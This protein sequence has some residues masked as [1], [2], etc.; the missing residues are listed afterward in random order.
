MRCFSW[1]V[2][3]IRSVARKQLL[4][5]EV[6]V[7]ADLI[8][9]QETKAQEH[10]LE[11]ELASPAGWHASWHSAEKAGY[12][13]V[14]I[15]SRDKPDEVVAGLGDPQFDVEGRV[16]SARFGSLWV[17]SAYFPNSQE[18]GRRLPYKLAFCAA[19]EAFTGRLRAGGREVLLMGDYNIAH[20]PIDL[21]RPKANERNA[22]YLPD[23][24]AWFGRWLGL[25]WRDVYRE[26]NP[27]LAGAYT[28][29]TAWG[30]ARAKNVGWRIDYGTVS[31]GLAN[32]VQDAA[33]HPT[34]MG[35]DHCPVSVVV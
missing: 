35:S 20:L 11:P 26:R 31:P 30:G 13:S 5:W 32:R 6:C 16:L 27:E 12:S 29:W 8:C 3:G 17:I 25:G 4:P 7:G 23:E 22:G 19:M 34:I 21:A 18:E 24:R 28:W 33:I 9:L 10:Q 15:L 1:N 2:N 14:A